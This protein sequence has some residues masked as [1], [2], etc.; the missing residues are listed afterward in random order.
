MNDPHPPHD[1][2]PHRPLLTNA[3]RP[4]T[5]TVPSIDEHGATGETPIAG[6]HA[7]TL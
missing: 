6:E 5:F 1:P 2:A 7:L 3:A 4:S